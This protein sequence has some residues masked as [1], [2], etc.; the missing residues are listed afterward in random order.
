MQTRQGKC[1][2]CRV[3]YWWVKCPGFRLIPLNQAYCPGGGEKL[4]ATTRLLRWQWHE[5]GRPILAFEAIKR[6]GPHKSRK[7]DAS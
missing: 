1:P 5:I 7:G 3:A 6:F 2:P 4:Q